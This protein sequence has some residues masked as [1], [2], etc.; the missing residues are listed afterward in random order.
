MILIMYTIEPR[1]R[2]KVRWTRSEA[3][4]AAV[5]VNGTLGGRPKKVRVADVA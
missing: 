1:V 4:A 5:R 3:K 2:L